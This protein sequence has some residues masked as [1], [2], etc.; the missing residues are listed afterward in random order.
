MDAKFQETEGFGEESSGKKKSKFKSIKKF[1]GK[2]KR[3]ETLSST[4]RGILK[5]SQS[6]SDVTAS[7]PI[8]VDYDS[9]DELEVQRSVMGSRALSHDSI[10]I[11]EAAPEPAGPVRV[12]SQEN[13]SD[14]IRA[15]QLKLHQNWKSGL[16]YA[17]GTP[18]KRDDPGMNS[19]DDGLPRSPPESSLLQEILNSNTAK[20]SDSHKHLSSLSLAGTGS[21]E[22]E[23]VTSSPLKSGSTDSQLF[24]RQSSAKIIT[25]RISDRSLSPPVDFDVP[26]E[27]SSCLDNSAAKHKLLVKPRN[28]RC[29]RTRRSPSKKWSES[30]NDLSST[31]D[32]GSDRKQMM[33]EQ[34]YEVSP[35]HQELTNSAA[36]LAAVASQ[37]P[38]M[39]KGLQQQTL[40]HQD[41]KGWMLHSASP[42]TDSLAFSNNQE[43]SNIMQELP[44][45]LL[46]SPSTYPKE[47]VATLR[48][49]PDQEKGH[50]E[51]PSGNL[52]GV[53]LS[54]INQEKNIFD[55]SSESHTLPNKDALAKN[56]VISNSNGTGKDLLK[57]GKA[58]PEENCN[59]RNIKGSPSV[60]NPTRPSSNNSFQSTDL[61]YSENSSISQTF[62]LDPP[63]QEDKS[64]LTLDKVNPYQGETKPDK[65]SHHPAVPGELILGGKAE[66]E[67]SDLSTLRKFSVSAACGRSKTGSLNIKETLECENLVF[68]QGL[69]GKTK[70]PSKTSKVEVEKISVE[71]HTSLAE[72]ELESPAHGL[73]RE[74]VA[75]QAQDL[76]SK[77][78]L[79]GSS[80]GLPQ[81]SIACQPSGEDKNPF[82]VKL[83]STSLYLKEKDRFSEEL[84]EIKRHSAEFNSGKGEAPV[85]FSL[86]GDKSEIRKT[87]DVNINSF[88]NK[89]L[90]IKPEQGS[91]KPPLPRKP[92]VQH[93]II[94]GTN[95]SIEKQEKI[96]SYPEFKNGDSSEK[97]PGPPEVA[98]ESVS[99]PGT[100][101]DLAKATDSPRMP[102]WMTA[103]KQ[104][105][106]A[107]EQDLSKEEKPMAQDKA[108]IAEKQITK[109]KTEE[110][111]KQQ[112]DFTRST[113]SSF[114][115][116][117][118]LE[119]QK[120]ETKLDTQESFAQ[121][122]LAVTS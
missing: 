51:M 53:S 104:K 20:F 56:D 48:L 49:S 4:G 28:Q 57:D 66:K 102:A 61:A 3:K 84:K 87:S 110:A 113:F 106:R 85:S 45:T 121:S 80:G 13:I 52:S 50:L 67:A 19:E 46:L 99:S 41:K 73:D 54:I 116:I 122:Q 26:P 5:P 109:L 22:E 82:H 115:L 12:F 16:P 94:S 59:E 47:D 70:N 10:F 11:P 8:P 37:Q 103:A 81:Q 7:L 23:Q 27:F 31:L 15:L 42:E 18:S 14:R 96:T 2:R 114:P 119:E 36:S 33:A 24:P 107:M 77:P 40:S 34:T 71:K 89:S 62:C 95:T 79:S 64:A 108:A 83:R 38:E 60:S 68:T 97:K 100:V 55:V 93:F 44:Q 25:V 6:T 88:L 43:S 112:T 72:S 120:K 32:D 105:Q 30:Q 90:R 74:G 91:T 21:E 39:T 17:F 111:V 65:E 78:V 101:V 35:S 117:V 92:I 9:E 58:L 63:P 76:G 86:Q 98:E 118:S 1:F 75:L 29:S 69:Q